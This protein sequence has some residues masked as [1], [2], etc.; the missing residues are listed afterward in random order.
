MS[1]GSYDYLEFKLEDNAYG[2][3][4]ME[5]LAKMVHDLTDSQSY[6]SKYDAAPEVGAQLNAM[7]AQ[8]RTLSGMAYAI[9]EKHAPLIHAVEWTVSSD[10]GKESIREAW[11][12]FLGIDAA[13]A[14]PA[15]GDGDGAK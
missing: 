12:A 10:W 8:L 15:N 1:G 9:V 14:A 11:N 6:I 2:G 13:L 3:N 5:L 7:R 4:A